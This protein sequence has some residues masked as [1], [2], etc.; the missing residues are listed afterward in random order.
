MP[1]DPSI[2]H[3][4][5]P[6]FNYVLRA[7]L[8]QQHADGYIQGDRNPDNS[9]YSQDRLTLTNYFVAA[10]Q[11]CGYD[12]GQ[13]IERVVRWLLEELPEQVEPLDKNG[14][15]RLEMLLNLAP[16][17][18]LLL[19]QGLAQDYVRQMVR[20]L[21]RQRITRATYEIR[22]ITDW[23]GN[24]WA[25]KLLTFAY[26]SEVFRH[27]RMR[28]QLKTDV[29]AILADQ[30]S[31]VRRSH[32]TLALALSLMYQLHGR[33]EPDHESLLDELLAANENR[34]GL[35]NARAGLLDQVQELKRYGFSANISR[36]DRQQWREALVGTCHVIEALAPLQD[37]YPQIS[38]ALD[39][40]MQALFDIFSGDPHEILQS[41]QKDYDWT[42]IMC[43]LLTAGRAYGGAEFQ[44]MILSTLVDSLQVEKNGWDRQ[45]VT[46]ALLNSFAITYK[47]EPTRLT[48]GLSGARVLRV[49]PEFTIR[50]P[51]KVD[52][53]NR[54]M[55]PGFE[56][57][58]VKYGTHDEIMAE[59]T[60]YKEHLDDELQGLFAP[61]QYTHSNADHSF[62]VIQNLHG[63]VSL[64]E[65]LRDCR[66]SEITGDLSDTLL[67]RVTRIHDLQ[68]PDLE[69]APDGLVRSLY[70][71]ALWRYTEVVFQN[72]RRRDMLSQIE[73][74][75]D[76]I[77]AAAADNERCLRTMIS[78]L[79]E[80]EHPLNQFPTARMHGDL[81]TRNIMIQASQGEIIMRFI[82]LEKFMLYGDYAIDVGQLSVNLKI[83]AQKADKPKKQPISAIENRLIENYNIYKN[84]LQ[85]TYY[86]A[87][88]SAAKARA[89]M[90]IAN[91]LAKGGRKLLKARPGIAADMMIEAL[92]HVE[93]AC[94]DLQYAARQ[95][96]NQ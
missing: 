74:R 39:H 19:D 59:Y 6:T 83:V 57:V 85:D 56:S 60:N 82:D 81:H 16:A 21:T 86:P 89:R 34:H 23:F 9:P 8:A 88:L 12:M 46:E 80:Y 28:S 94:R 4:L 35:W 15:N 43:R 58:I 75:N 78:R 96:E 38:P 50:T 92:E 29:K 37:Q 17:P 67:R 42:L 10:L 95:L 53:T 41:F 24:V 93:L 7:L 61:V 20:Q 71:E 73:Q 77:L 44:R 55:P 91:G 22:D 31:G 72:L 87:R 76:D 32:Q 66:T 14:L 11:A 1:A 5:S 47:D 45:G 54:V 49:E 18:Q 3:N 2:L 40:A 25:I 69:P 65:Y 84:H 51:K 70:F 68:G 36:E 48:L 33:L 63:F 30:T 90:R 52:F 79:Y 26:D 62:I 27:H 13:Y 64:E